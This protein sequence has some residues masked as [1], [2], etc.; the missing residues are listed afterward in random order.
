MSFSVHTRAYSGPFDLLLALVSRQKVDISQVSV[1]EV[2]DQ[3][4]EEVE[5]MEDLDLEVASDFLLVAATLLDMKASA[6][7]PQDYRL[8]PTEDEGE[9]EAEVDLDAET[10]REVLIA[11]LIAY[12]QIRSASMALGSRMQ[13]TSRMVPRT[14]GP[15]PEFLEVVPDYLAGISLRSIAVIAADITARRDAVLL[16]AEHVAPRRLPIAIAVAT[17]ERILHVQGRQTFSELLAGERTADKVVSTFLAILELYKAGTVRLEQ[18]ELFGEIEVS[19]ASE[20]G[21]QGQPSG[22]ALAE[23]EL[24]EENHANT[25]QD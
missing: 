17:I 16:E 3:Y 10:A 9:D 2:A 1:T 6:L 5:R 15:D 24:G 21:R 22:D 18:S 23:D 14:V 4:L 7:V 25:G 20:G 13:A 11:R 19:L 12:K 8:R